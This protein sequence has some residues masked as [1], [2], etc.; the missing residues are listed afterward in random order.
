MGTERDSLLSSLG[1]FC[2]SF[3]LRWQRKEVLTEQENEGEQAQGSDSFQQ[4]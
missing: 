4:N 3:I 2:G 1:C